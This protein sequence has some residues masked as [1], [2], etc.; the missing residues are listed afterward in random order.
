MPIENGAVYWRQTLR[1]SW[2]TQT[3]LY[4]KRPKKSS[5]KKILTKISTKPQ[6]SDRIDRKWHF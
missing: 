1:F 3:K 6:L 2:L 5:D 4:Q